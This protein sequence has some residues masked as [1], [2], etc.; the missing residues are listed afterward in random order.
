MANSA[1]R[2][3]LA[4]LQKPTD[5]DLRCLQKK[6]IWQ[7]LT[8]KKQNSWPYGILNP[9]QKKSIILTT[10]GP[11]TDFSNQ[12]QTFFNRLSLETSFSMSFDT[13]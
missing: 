12:A 4:S 1:D 9:E 7:G 3:Q 13:T 5:L 10:I 6:D 8:S 11:T 2:D